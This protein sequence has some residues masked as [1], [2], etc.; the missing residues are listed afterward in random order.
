MQEDNNKYKVGETI[1]DKATP[2]VEL[3]VRRYTKRIY[4][5]TVANNP[6]EKEI[7]LFER[8]IIDKDAK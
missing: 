1:Y 3:V 5:C 2:D 6:T 8:E 7:V 4:Y